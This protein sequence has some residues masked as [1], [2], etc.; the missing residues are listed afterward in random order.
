MR[1]IPS[2]MATQ[3]PDNAFT[4]FWDKNN[5]PFIPTYKEIKEALVCFDEL[6]ISEYMWDW[7]GKH[8]DASVID[9]LFSDSYAYFKNHQLGKD[10][11]LTFRIPNIWEER[12]YNLLQ[13]MT[14]ILSSEDFSKDLKF[15]N[16]PLF[17]VIL[18]MTERPEQLMRIH[19][20]FQK[21]AQFKNKDFTKKEA[22]NNEYIELIPLVESVESQLEVDKLLTK[23]VGLHE[24]HFG[25]KPKYIRTFLA[26]SDSALTSGFLSGI[27]G[28]KLALVRLEEFSK[29][30]GI[31]IYPIMGSGGLIFRGGL[32]PK[33]VDRFIQEFPGVKTV[34][35]QS[36]FRYDYPESEVIEAVK[37]LEDELPKS[38][39]RVI[40]KSEQD[41]IVEIA[42]KSAKIYIDSLHK[43]TKEIDELFKSMPK[44]RERRQHTGLLA[45]SRSLDG[46]KLPRAITFTGG[47]YSIGLPPEF[48]GFGRSLKMLSPS[49][50]DLLKQNYPSLVDDFKHVGRYIN[51]SNLEIL[52]TKNSSWKQIIEDVEL[53]EE[54]LNVQFTPKTEDEKKHQKITS[55]ILS[56]IENAEV[57]KKLIPESAELRKSVG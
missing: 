56:N 35:I 5:G 36:S 29:Q 31:P 34:S 1:K 52:A 53:A 19:K 41:I 9:R 25:F 33:L 48:I 42:H 22:D 11:Y 57:I 45:Y 51:K 27:L 38:K 20:L 2:T 23:Y 24:Q 43:I 10:K 18:P 50:L 17:E 54:I 26:C 12:G 13:A 47:F 7:E 30:S 32:S 3:H 39:S 37:K 40:Q 55:E 46:Q 14:V 6:G 4:P 44:R 16:R 8:A 15:E 49:E 28:N 21:L